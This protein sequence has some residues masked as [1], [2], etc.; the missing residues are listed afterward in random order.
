MSPQN[1]I[2]HFLRKH[3]WRSD[4]QKWRVVDLM[5]QGVEKLTNDRLTVKLGFT[6]PFHTSFELVPLPS[7]L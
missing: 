6:V 4:G 3:K 5:I 2:E 1:S 7:Q